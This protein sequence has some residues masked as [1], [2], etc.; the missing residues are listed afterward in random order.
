MTPR[1]RARFNQICRAL[2]GHLDRHDAA[3]RLHDLQRRGD[4]ERFEV[5]AEAV[6]VV[7]E[8]R[9]E[10]GVD[11]RGRGALVLTDHWQNVARAGDEHLGL[12]C[13]AHDLGDAAFMRRVGVGMQQADR[14][15]L[16]I[17]V[18]D[19]LGGGANAFFVQRDAHL[20]LWPQ[21]LDNLEPAPPRHQ[22]DRASGS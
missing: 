12:H 13:L 18:G 2:G 16:D 20:A 8:R 15:R 17:A 9:S 3:V 5:P 1:R 4:A 11:H 22:A 7:S 6:Q 14:D 21:P 10:I 19:A